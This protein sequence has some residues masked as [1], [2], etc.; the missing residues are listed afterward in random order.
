[1]NRT[2]PHLLTEAMALTAKDQQTIATIIMPAIAKTFESTLGAAALQTLVKR[3]LEQAS[4][5]RRFQD[6]NIAQV[7]W[8]NA[9]KDTLT[10]AEFAKTLG[11]FMSNWIALA[12]KTVTPQA[13][14]PGTP[15][16]TGTP[17]PP[18]T[19]RR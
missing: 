7:D 8:L 17:T 11:P 1:M 4:T 15:V 6:P 12:A 14:A 13:Q 5:A 2:P 3:G 18:V 9:L 19:A 10:S 16:T